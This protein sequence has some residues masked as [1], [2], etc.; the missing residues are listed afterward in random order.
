MI[1]RPPRSTLVPYTTLFRA[2][3]RAFV[4]GLGTDEADDAIVAAVVALA[5]ALGLSVVAAGVESA[6]QRDAVRELG[7][8]I[9]QGFL[10]ARPRSDEH[11]SEFQ[12]RQYLVCRLL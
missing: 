2:I 5:Q 11:T 4:A 8:D 10:F 9:G 7:C 3:D 6:Q 1:R 12:S